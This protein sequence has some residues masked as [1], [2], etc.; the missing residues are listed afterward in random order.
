MRTGG[1]AAVRTLGIRNLLDHPALRGLQT[2][3]ALAAMSDDTVRVLYCLVKGATSF[4]RIS[5]S[6]NNNVYDLMEMVHDMGKNGIL[7]GTD[8]PDLFVW[9]VRTTLRLE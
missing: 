4:M 1:S 6:V 5:L 2:V 9:K 8:V 3:T 7:R